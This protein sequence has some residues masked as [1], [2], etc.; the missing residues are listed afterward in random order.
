MLDNWCY[1]ILGELYNYSGIPSIENKKEYLIFLREEFP[2]LV[3]TYFWSKTE[4]NIQK[5]LINENFNILKETSVYALNH[6]NKI[7]T[8][9]QLLKYLLT[10][11]LEEMINQ[12]KV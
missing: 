11:N 9:L 2:E 8:N 10:K 6:N 12:D 5:I 7:P 4:T 1:E 3:E